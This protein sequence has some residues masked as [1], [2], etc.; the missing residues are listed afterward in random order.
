MR[1]IDCLEQWWRTSDTRSRGGT[2]SPLCGHAHRR[3]STEFIIRK[4]E[5][6]G[7]RLLPSSGQPPKITLRRGK[8]VNL[9]VLKQEHPLSQHVTLEIITFGNTTA[10]YNIVFGNTILVLDGKLLW[11]FV[12]TN[13]EWSQNTSKLLYQ[14]FRFTQ[15]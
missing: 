1:N 14:M 13:V 8:L 3:P 9:P 15:W 11:T 12:S 5:A 2:R 10:S 7:S 6:R 4:I